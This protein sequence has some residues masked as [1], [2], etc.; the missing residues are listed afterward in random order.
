MARRVVGMGGTILV[1]LVGTI[2]AS[3]CSSTRT[4]SLWPDG[5][6]PEP[7]R[8]VD[9]R[10]GVGAIGRLRGWASGASQARIDPSQ[11]H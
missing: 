5:K 6:R 8:D 4:S 9:N 7:M 1:L 3:G 10:Q 11:L 2:G